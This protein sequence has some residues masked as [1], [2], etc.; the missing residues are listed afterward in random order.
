MLLTLKTIVSIQGGLY[1]QSGQ[2]GDAIYLQANSFEED[3]RLEDFIQPNLVLDKKIEKHL[4]AE[5][6]VL[7]AAK[8]AKNFAA[9]ITPKMGPCVASST[10]L[11]LRLEQEQRQR[12]LPE[13]LVWF[14][15]HPNTQRILKSK[16][17]GTGVMSISKKELEELIVTLP[18]LKTQ[19]TIIII[20]DLRKRE[21]QLKKSIEQLKEQQIQQLLF[22][23][24]GG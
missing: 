9:L 5:G 6:D 19:Q 23:L 14:L 22:N 1:T 2:N 7:F 10:F 15:N 4:L 12:I 11:V 21:K 16:A 17:L 8:G 20:D 24:T 13:F 18:D 3:G